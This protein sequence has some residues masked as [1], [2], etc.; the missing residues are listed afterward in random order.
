MKFTI[1]LKRLEKVKKE[2][3]ENMKDKHVKYFKFFKFSAVSLKEG[4]TNTGEPFYALEVTGSPILYWY[5]KFALRKTNHVI[6]FWQDNWMHYYW[7]R[8][9]E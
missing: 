6:P 5:F 1:T 8:K 7:N 2:F 4:L 9:G 3:E